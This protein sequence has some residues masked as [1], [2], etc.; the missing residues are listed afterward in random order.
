MARRKTTSVS[1]PRASAIQG[2]N[3]EYASTDGNSGF[4]K[5]KRVK[6][7]T[8]GRIDYNAPFLKGLK[9]SMFASWDWND[10]DSKTFAYA[11]KVMS[12]NPSTKRYVYR[13]CANLMGRR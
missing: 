13:N 2:H 12:Y 9:V 10:T 7:E 1:L 4:Q 3:P 11:Y 6:M 8:A 5:T